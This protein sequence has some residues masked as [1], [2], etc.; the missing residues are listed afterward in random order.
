MA[1]LGPREGGKTQVLVYTVYQLGLGLHGWY[2]RQNPSPGTG[3]RFVQHALPGA[4]VSIM[5]VTERSDL[6][7]DSLRADNDT[8]HGPWSHRDTHHTRA[9]SDLAVALGC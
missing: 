4:D 3:S 5:V 6:D 7:L 2:T 1:L 9:M 8:S